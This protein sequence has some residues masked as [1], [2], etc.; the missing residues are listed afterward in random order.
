M[1]VSVLP[2]DTNQPP[3]FTRCSANTPAPLPTR[4][5]AAEPLALERTLSDL[6]NQAYALAAAENAL[7]WKTAPCRPTNPAARHRLRARIPKGFRSPK[8]C[9]TH[10]RQFEELA[11]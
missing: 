1:Q 9:Q 6:V 2:N 10:L 7:L 3:D 8:A 5:L 11:P 4:A